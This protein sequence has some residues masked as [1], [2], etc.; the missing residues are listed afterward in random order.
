MFCSQIRP[1]YAPMVATE[2]EKYIEE[3]ESDLQNA[4]LKRGLLKAVIPV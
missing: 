3:Q 2:E 4:A 1:E